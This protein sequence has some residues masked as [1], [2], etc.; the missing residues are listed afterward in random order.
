MSGEKPSLYTTGINHIEWTEVRHR[1]E[2]L[3]RTTQYRQQR[4]GM[5]CTGGVR[6]VAEKAKAY[7]LLNRMASWQPEALRDGPIA[8]RTRNHAPPRQQ[9]DGERQ[10]ATDGSVWNS[11]TLTR[12][13]EGF[14]CGVA[15]ST[16]G[17]RRSDSYAYGTMAYRTIGTAAR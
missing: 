17:R 3:N 6:M 8:A 10:E 15:D 16:K 13:R 12:K 2:I 9:V 1:A 4:S 5:R 14:S 11:S 7:G